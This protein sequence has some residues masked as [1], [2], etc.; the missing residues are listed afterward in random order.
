M[1]LAADIKIAT[2][3]SKREGVPTAYIPLVMVVL[4]K[5]RMT[6]EIVVSITCDHQENHDT[7]CNNLDVSRMSGSTGGERESSFVSE[8]LE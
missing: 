3:L 4:A 5:I 8:V 1:M 2:P 6:L 7:R